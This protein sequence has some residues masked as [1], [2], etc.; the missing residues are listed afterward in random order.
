V[1]GGY[2][3]LLHLSFFRNPPAT[4]VQKPAYHRNS[5]PV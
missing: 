1:Q 4:M 2:A 5:R 3:P